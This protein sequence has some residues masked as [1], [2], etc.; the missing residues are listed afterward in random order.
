MLL[1]FNKV[2]D[3]YFIKAN[4]S[5]CKKTKGNVV[6][7]IYFVEATFFLKKATKLILIFFKTFQILQRFY[8]WL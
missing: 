1:Y 7:S 4:S 5:L 8:I 2:G 3:L 6:I